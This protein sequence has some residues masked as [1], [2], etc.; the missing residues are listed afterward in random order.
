M[1]PALTRFHTGQGCTALSRHGTLLQT[2]RS[3]TLTFYEIPH[4][5]SLDLSTTCLLPKLVTRHTEW[6]GITEDTRLL[7]V[8]V[9]YL[10]G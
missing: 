5:S 9:S 6:G 10:G 2:S 3:H 8:T 7:K 1:H 4:I